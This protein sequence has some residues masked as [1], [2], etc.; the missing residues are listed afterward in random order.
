MRPFLLALCLVS[1]AAAQFEEAESAFESLRRMSLSDLKDAAAGMPAPIAR[2]VS[3]R[4]QDGLRVSDATVAESERSQC[5]RK[6]EALS[7]SPDTDLFTYIGFRWVRSDESTCSASPSDK[8]LYIEE[9]RDR[10][11]FSA[12]PDLEDPSKARAEYD[13]AL[14]AP[15]YKIRRNYYFR[16]E[17]DGT[18]RFYHHDARLYTGRKIPETVQVAFPNRAA[19]PL[20]PWEEPES[21]T[22]RYG[23]LEGALLAPERKV[24]DYLPR[25]TNGTNAAGDRMTRIEL[26]AQRKMALTGPDPAGVR[27]SL[28]TEGSDLMLRLEDRWA[29]YYAGEKIQL[30]IKLM[31]SVFWF[32]NKTAYEFDVALDVD[33]EIRIIP[34]SSLWDAFR[35]DGISRGHEYQAEWSFRRADS[36]ISGGDWVPKGKTNKLKL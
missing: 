36:K 25:A 8:V 32:V 2:P 6:S 29:A 33:R 11:V 10:L 18:R 12:P 14:T 20:L 7:G 28:E 21:F 30:K 26:T 16:T 22:L 24:Y 35:K 3:R 9:Q 4:A 17:L 34:T 27:L 1:P 31:K 23:R 19:F 5:P 15:E 13:Y